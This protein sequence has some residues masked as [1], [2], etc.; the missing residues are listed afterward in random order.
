MKSVQIDRSKML[1][2]E[3]HTGHNRWHPD[4]PPILE[5]EPGEEV[6]LDTRDA[7]DGQF[8]SGTTEA[9]F[10]NLDAGLI[11]P[12]TG[13]VFVKGA[14]PGDL[15]EVQFIAIKP[16]PWAFTAIIPGFGFL[17]DLYTDP[18]MVHWKI[19]NNVATSEQLPR[20]RVP[21]APFMGVS[22]LAPSL[23]L[24]D[25]W[26]RRENDAIAAGGMALPP[27]AA[28][29]VPSEGPGAIQGS[30]T[31]PPRE[32]GGNFDVKQ[33]TAGSKLLL[34]VYVDGAFF[35]TG[36]AHF[37]QGDGEVCVTAV[38]MAATVT[39]RFQVHKG[40]AAKNNIRA[41]RFS[42]PD[43]FHTP[44]MASP[45]DFVA[46]M[47][48]PIRE[49]GTNEAENLTLACRNAV[50]HM[51]ELLQERGFS[52]EQAYAICS[53]GVDLRVSNVVDVPNFTVSAILPEAIFSSK[54]IHDSN[55]QSCMVFG[56]SRYPV[57]T[58]ILQKRIAGNDFPVPFSSR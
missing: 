51:T 20:V 58:L 55:Q 47:G 16:Q 48:Y 14:A 2:A 23:E 52:P 15:L 38:E 4:I 8:H 49:D 31:L 46:V 45:K 43:Y 32:C 30:R 26:T 34:P 5:V 22:G 1:H 35:S 7:L 56:G 37:A 18:F 13:P 21:G 10:A 41:P 3:P 17:R 40:V 39:L 12:L 44:E 36:D 6:M 25:Q 29:A 19:E 53:V 9:D 54:E 42:H 11:H 24:L 28:G 33:L 50:I 57:R 27:D